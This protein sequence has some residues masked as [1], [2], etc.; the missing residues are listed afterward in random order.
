M[1][2]VLCGTLSARNTG[3]LAIWFSSSIYWA[4]R[5]GAPPFAA[6]LKP[7]GVYHSRAEKASR[8]RPFSDSLSSAPVRRALVAALAPAGAP[9]LDGLRR[10]AA[11]AGHTVG[12]AIAPDRLSVR[13]AD[14]AQ[15]ADRLALP[16]ADTRIRYGKGLG[17]HVEPVEPPID[18]PGFE[19]VQHPRTG[20]REVLPRPDALRRPLQRRRRVCNDAL[21]GFL[22]RGGEHGDIVLRHDHRQRPPAIQAQRRAQRPVF[23]RSTADI[24]PA[25]HDKVGLPAAGKT[26]AVQKVREHPGKP[27][28]IGGGD[29]HPRPIRGQLRRRAGADIP[30]GIHAGI[31]QPVRQQSGAVPAVSRPR[32]IYDHGGSPLLS[33]PC[34]RIFP[35]FM[36]PY[37]LRFA[38]AFRRRTAFRAFCVFFDIHADCPLHRRHLCLYNN[39]V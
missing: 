35:P 6:F 34:G 24:L 2:S 9:V 20:H 30:E 38:R 21:R 1:R 10:A 17:T 8:S 25:G 18:D 14:V 36:I 29:E 33:A 31:S 16:A 19:P 13:Q 28:G 15:R 5:Q 26:A 22:V 3:S 12:A 39:K 23:L 11:D 7:T 37:P 4:R 32:K 27:P